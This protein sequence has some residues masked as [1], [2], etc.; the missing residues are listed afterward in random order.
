MEEQFIRER[1]ERWV[2]G[3]DERCRQEKWAGV[4]T[5]L[6]NRA[7][8]NVTTDSWPE[9]RSLLYDHRK[10]TTSK[11]YS[12][13]FHHLAEI[14]KIRYIVSFLITI[15]HISV[16]AKTTQLRC[17]VGVKSWFWPA[18]VVPH[19]LF[20]LCLSSG[21]CVDSFY[22]SSV[23]ELYKNTFQFVHWNIKGKKPFIFPLN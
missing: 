6:G 15:W 21:L 8:K 19:S 3:W 13:F 9:L 17:K 22:F 12:C 5:G 10:A 18:A 2:N 16:A 4:Q 11:K 23:F 7:D 1:L 20:L 14:F